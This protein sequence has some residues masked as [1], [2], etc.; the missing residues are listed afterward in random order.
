[1]TEPHDP[2]RLAQ[3]DDRIAALKH[4]QDEGPE[5]EEH[6]S[7]AQVG[8][9]MVTELVTGL[10]LGFGIGYGMDALFGTI[11]IF[12]VLFIFAGFAAG[13]RVM[14]RT[15]Q[16]LQKETLEQSRQKKED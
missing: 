10:L 4:T 14:L 3:L 11:P 9:R 1:M 12:T 16:E 2:K 7:Q 13:V 5:V 8:W 6:Y 15:A